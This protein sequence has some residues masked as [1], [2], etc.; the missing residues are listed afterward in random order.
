MDRMKYQFSYFA[1]LL[2]LVACRGEKPDK[3]INQ[4]FEKEIKNR[5]ELIATLEIKNDS[6]KVN[7]EALDEEINQFILLS[8]DIENLSAA[9]NRSNAYFLNLSHTYGLNYS[10]FTELNTGMHINEM[11]T[12]LKKNELN[13]LNQLIFKISPAQAIPFTAQ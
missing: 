12:I 8:K 1:V 10:D 3:N 9:V 6:L 4:Y 2:L 13:F 5:C 7:C 11:A